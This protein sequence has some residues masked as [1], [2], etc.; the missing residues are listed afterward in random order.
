MEYFKNC[1]GQELEIIAMCGF[2]TYL[3]VMVMIMDL[4]VLLVAISYIGS[5]MKFCIFAW[6]AGLFW[7]F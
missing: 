6:C 1:K 3:V 5:G 4:V 2:R 7:V